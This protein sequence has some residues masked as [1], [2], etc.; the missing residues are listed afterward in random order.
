MCMIVRFYRSTGKAA[1]REML[2]PLINNVLEDKN[3]HININPV[4]VYKQW[5][6]SMEYNSGQVAGMPY[7]VTAEQALKY[8]EV[9][10]RLQKSITKLKQVTTMFLATIV[11]SGKKM[12][13][14]I[15]YIAKVMSCMFGVYHLTNLDQ[16]WLDLEKY[17][18]STKNFG[19]TFFIFLI[20]LRLLNV[21]HLGID[22]VFV[23]YF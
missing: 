21:F 12:P 16:Y 1:L 2:T 15:Q 3:L 6:N 17:S 23:I 8:E 4:D 14:G 5:I 7:D 20:V 18:L 19:Q 9:Q 10:K 11:K 22:D 13:Y